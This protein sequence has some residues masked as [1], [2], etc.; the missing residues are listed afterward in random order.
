[1]PMH[2][3]AEIERRVLKLAATSSFL[4]AGLPPSFANSQ[5]GPVARRV[6]P[7]DPD[8]PTPTE[9]NRLD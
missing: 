3:D 4:L 8:W 6:R 9:W 5:L 2:N 7:S 1:M